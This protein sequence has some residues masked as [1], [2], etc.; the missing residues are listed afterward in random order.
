MKV[1]CDE[2]LANHIGPESCA[3]GREAVGEALTGVRVGQPLSG[4]RLHVRSADALQS[5]EGN[6]GGALCECHSGSAS[7][8]DPGMHV[9][10]A[11]GSKRS[12][13]PPAPAVARA[14]W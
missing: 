10:L 4:E 13:Y 6:T 5:A 8:E 2:G 14:A 7:S 11:S 1:P 12:A 9:R 3:G